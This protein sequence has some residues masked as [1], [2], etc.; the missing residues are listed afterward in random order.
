VV[1]QADERHLA[2]AAPGLTLL[3]CLRVVV[4]H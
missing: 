3:P 2:S 1:V 4:A